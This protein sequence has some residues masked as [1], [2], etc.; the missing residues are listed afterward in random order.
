MQQQ[1]LERHKNILENGRK[2]GEK[3]ERGRGKGKREKGGKRV[4]TDV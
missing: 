3:G 1:R 4:I 2:D